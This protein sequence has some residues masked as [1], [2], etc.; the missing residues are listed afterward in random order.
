MNQEGRNLAEFPAVGKACETASDLT[1]GSF[2]S[3]GSSPEGLLLFQSV[4]LFTVGVVGDSKLCF[5]W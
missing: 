2:D 1:E 3:S 5:L 4:V